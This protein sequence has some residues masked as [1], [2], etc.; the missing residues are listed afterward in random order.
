MC[1]K[2]MNGMKKKKKKKDLWH[3][4]ASSWWVRHTMIESNCI[5]CGSASTRSTQIL[6]IFPL[7]SEYEVYSDHLCT[8]VR[9]I[10][11]RVGGAI[12]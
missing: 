9:S 3:W 11:V 5:G 2:I 10:G 4:R 12:P 8:V 7:Y 6:S 1:A